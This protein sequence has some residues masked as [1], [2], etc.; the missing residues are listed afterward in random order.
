MG[1]RFLAI[2][3]LLILC[4]LFGTCAFA[5]KKSP[6]QPVNL[7]FGDS[8]RTATSAGNRASN[9]EKNLAAAEVVR[10]VQER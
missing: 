8:G 4:L 2:R 9:G 7:K 10:R 5:K 6:A 3:I 1:W